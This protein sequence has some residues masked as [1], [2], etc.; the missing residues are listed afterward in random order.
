MTYGYGVVLDMKTHLASPADPSLFP[1][2]S[3]ELQSVTSRKEHLWSHLSC[4][5]SSL[6]EGR[7]RLLFLTGNLL[8]IIILSLPQLPSIH[9]HTHTHS[10]FVKMVLL[11]PLVTT[12]CIF[13]FVKN[14][15]FLSQFS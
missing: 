4:S 12:N 5:S 13:F 15:P 2:Q 3:C 11:L 10:V 7:A 8:Q 1:S 14:S 6:L 9:T